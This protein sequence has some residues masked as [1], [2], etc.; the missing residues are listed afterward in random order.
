[1][2]LRVL[3]LT[4][5]LLGCTGAT[6]P[7]DI[8]AE[9]LGTSTDLEFVIAPPLAEPAPPPPALEPPPTP[10]PTPARWEMWRIVEDVE[11]SLIDELDP[12]ACDVDL[13]E[14]PTISADGTVLALALANA[15]VADPRLLT[16]RMLRT[17]DAK[18]VRAYTLIGLGESELAP[19]ELQRRICHRASALA[20]ALASGGH[21]S[22]PVVGGWDNPIRDGLPERV[23]GWPRVIGDGATREVDMTV[24]DI[25]I[26]PA[27]ADAPEL[28]L[29][30]AGPTVCT[31]SE[32]DEEEFSQVWEAGGLRVFTR[33]PCGC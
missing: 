3:L 30:T 14:F 22:A 29:R 4:A 7:L 13:P 27:S 15:P 19:E 17:D 23:D 33:G 25:V 26:A 5:S 24:A 32:S 1:M 16:I 21:T 20:R 9:Q 18:Q 2:K 6:D 10:E 31:G 8:E 28:R 12:N 11:G